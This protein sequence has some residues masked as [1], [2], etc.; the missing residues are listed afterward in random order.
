[1]DFMVGLVGGEYVPTT[2]GNEPV[3]RHSHWD[4]SIKGVLNPLWIN[5][6]DDEMRSTS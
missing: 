6:D 5:S 4:T 3:N 2:E 1:M